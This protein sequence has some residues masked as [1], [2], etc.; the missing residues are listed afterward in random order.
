[1]P[2]FTENKLPRIKGEMVLAMKNGLLLGTRVPTR[3]VML[4][5]PSLNAIIYVPVMLI[6]V[7]DGVLQ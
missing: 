1:M 5:N 3:M 2:A 7:M 4:K 6:W